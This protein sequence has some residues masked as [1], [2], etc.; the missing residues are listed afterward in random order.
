MSK[1]AKKQKRVKYRETEETFYPDPSRY[2]LTRN[3]VASILRVHPRTVERWLK[4][5]SLRGYKLGEGR[6]SLWR[7]SEVE[8]MEFL[9]KHRKLSLKEQKRIWQ[10][11]ARR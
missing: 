5:D 7:I 3:E 8:L 4:S 1:Q 6:T 2:F 10:T 9:G 11:I